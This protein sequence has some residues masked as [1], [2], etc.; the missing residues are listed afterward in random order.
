M[1]RINRPE[2][3]VEE[4]LG[5]CVDNMTDAITKS[6][7]EKAS[8]VKILKDAELDFDNKKLTNTIYLIP[9]SLGINNI[10]DASKL[11]NLYTGRLINKNNKG[12]K[13]YDKILSSAPNGLCPL[14][15]Q[16]NATT[17]DH[18]LPKSKYPL[19]SIVPLNL[20]PACKDCNTGKLCDSPCN[21]VEETLHPYYDNVEDFIWLKSNV[22][23]PKPF[24][25]EYYTDP[26]ADIDPLLRDRIKYHFDNFSLGRL[27]KVH[28]AEEFANI[29]IQL[30]NVFRKGGQDALVDFLKECHYSRE[31]TNKN[32]WQTAFYWGLL[33]SG[34][35]CNGAFI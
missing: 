16:R 22:R 11:T 2:F 7:F 21:N 23:S 12:R 32:S 10:I 27:Y 4:V 5:A 28:A 6:E 24:L 13:Y 1:R 3:T 30:A 14:C 20:V 8:S 15:N 31:I 26:P 34:D 29:K 35:F 18:Y 9:K 25:I 19:L 17:L 33:N